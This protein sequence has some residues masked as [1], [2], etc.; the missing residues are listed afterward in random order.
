MLTR[1]FFTP[2]VSVRLASLRKLARVLRRDQCS[3][4]TCQTNTITPKNR[5]TASRTRTISQV[6]LPDNAS[7]REI[8][9]KA[10]GLE[11]TIVTVR[12]GETDLLRP[13]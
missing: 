2:S 11:R 7:D 10:W 5:V 3:L 9:A 13:S 12:R 1:F 4:L 6:G 8:V